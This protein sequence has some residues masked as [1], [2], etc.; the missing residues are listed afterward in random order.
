MT[1]YEKII[2][3]VHQ[4][5]L[6]IPDT[7]DNGMVGD[8]KELKNHVKKQNGRI[9]KLEIAVVILVCSGTIGGLE[10]ADIIHLVGG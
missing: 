6:G 2:N 4:A 9:R 5:V 3:E 10:M 8:L 1:K 7:E